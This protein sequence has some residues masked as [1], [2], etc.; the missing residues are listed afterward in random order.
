MVLKS[1]FLVNLVTLFQFAQKCITIS[2][3]SLWIDHVLPFT[4]FQDIV[5]VGVTW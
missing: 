5:I 2:H 4:T 1:K 3:V